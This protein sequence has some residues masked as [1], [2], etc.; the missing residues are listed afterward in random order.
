M[1]S[2]KRYPIIAICNERLHTVLQ[3]ELEGHRTNIII[4][5]LCDND[6]LSYVL[7]YLSSSRIIYN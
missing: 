3:S 7:K 2:A 1:R 6:C 4:H 5:G